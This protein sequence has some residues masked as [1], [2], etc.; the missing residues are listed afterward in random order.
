[1]VQGEKGGMTRREMMKYMGVVGAAASAS[2][3]LPIILRYVTPNPQWPAEKGEI[4]VGPVS[5]GSVDKIPPLTVF[6]F[7]FG[8][9]PLP[10]ILLKF[11]S[12]PS[13]QKM[14]STE[15]SGKDISGGEPDPGV[16]SGLIAYCLKCVHLGCIVGTDFISPNVIECPCHFARYDLHRGAAVVGG[17][18]PAPIPEI[19]LEVKN[20]ELIAKGWRDIDYVKSLAVYKAVV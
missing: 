2:A 11:D 3:P 15:A 16:P 6:S 8:K 13:H 18:A 12:P 1:M 7:N 17:P 20:G 14:G 10:G 4:P 19:A 9:V 5:L